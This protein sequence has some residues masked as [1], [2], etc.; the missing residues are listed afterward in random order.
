[1]LVNLGSVAL[2]IVLHATFDTLTKVLAGGSSLVLL[3]FLDL[4]LSQIKERRKAQLA[5]DEWLFDLLR[6]ATE[7]ILQVSNPPV[8]RLRASIL[9]PNEERSVLRIAYSYNYQ[10]EDRDSQIVIPIGAG[11][12]GQAW[13]RQ[14]AVIADLG[15]MDAARMPMQ[16]GLTDSEVEK[17]RPSTKSILC[18]P[19]QVE[20][21]TIGV[22]SFD[23]ENSMH[24][25]QFADR[26]VQ[27]LAYSFSATIGSALSADDADV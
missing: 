24:E 13:V 18:I 15:E 2:S 11:C 14:T 19:I 27:D 20:D 12:A 9:V 8:D 10:P 16:W 3:A 7:S 25:I 21:R 1:M 4:S 6:A 26:H 5:R 17:I 23:S 22:L